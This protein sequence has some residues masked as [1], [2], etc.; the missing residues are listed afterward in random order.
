[1]PCNDLK[2]LK[3]NIVQKLDR[4][5]SVELLSKIALYELHIQSPE[6]HDRYN[7]ASENSFAM[8]VSRL[9]LSNNI[10]NEYDPNPKEYFEFKNLLDD[11]FKS[12]TLS[13]L[14]LDVTSDQ[15]DHIRFQSQLERLSNDSNPHL[16]PHQKLDI[17]EK[18]FL[19]LNGYFENKYGFSIN[20]CK[21]FVKIILDVLTDHMIKRYKFADQKYGEILK[22]FKNPNTISE[23]KT[24]TH[25]LENTASH[26]RTWALLCAAKRTMV[27]NIDEY[28]KNYDISKKK[29]FMNFLNA[30]SCTTGDQHDKFDNPL[31]SNILSVKP[32][33]KIDDQSFLIIK[34][35]F[36]FYNL[37]RILEN[38][39]HEEK[40]SQSKIWHKLCDLKSKYLENKT[41]EFF[42]R[43]FPKKNM[44]TNIYYWQDGI[45]H[46]TDLLIKYD[47]KIFIIE[48]KS[49]NLPDYAL[50]TGKTALKQRLKEL[51]DKS[52]E[53]A[54][55]AKNYI[56]VQKNAK[57]WDMN[58]Q[59]ILLEI[60]SSDT[61]Y[62]FYF[63]T[64]TS[65][66]IGSIALNPKELEKI[67]FFKNHTYPTSMYI[68]HL[69]VL[70]DMLKE[71]SYIIHYFEERERTQSENIL[72]SS[73]ELDMMG[74][75]MK[76]GNLKI[77]YPGN[78]FR[79]SLAEFCDEIIDH[80]DSNKPKPYFLYQKHFP[81]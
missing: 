40:Q 24:N 67:G 17:L 80:Y 69:D 77:F 20:T 15:T 27:I 65:A 43:I 8:F 60:N 68:H 62:D 55:A 5:G 9:C 1:M 63:I 45:R 79:I 57:F 75:Y 23:S 52:A 12:F 35:D 4:I 31:S 81:N 48:S 22:S 34:P 18:V 76:N 13:L 44:F 73:S 70:T 16:F 46:E 26:Y 53:Q 42:E 51:M 10:Q 54:I 72:T 36:L 32:I 19:P 14:G 28:C 71:P 25:N 58:K 38:L 47:D 2:N 41:V 78:F 74:Y 3:A 64:M 50:Q 30:V 49:G 7:P 6:F 29:P 37:D 66:Y 56:I 39:L 59:N 11:Y 33:I 61:N 21:E